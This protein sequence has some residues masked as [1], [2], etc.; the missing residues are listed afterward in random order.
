[1]DRKHAEFDF[2]LRLQCSIIELD[3][4]SDPDQVRNMIRFSVRS[5]KSPDYTN[6]QL[7]A[8]SNKP[9]P[10]LGM[11]PDE[12]C[13]STK[14]SCDHPCA[15]F[16]WCMT[17]CIRKVH[18]TVTFLKVCRFFTKTSKTVS[19]TLWPLGWWSWSEL[20]RVV[21][22]KKQ[23]QNEIL[24]KQTVSPDQSGYWQLYACMN[25]RHHLPSHR[26]DSSQ[27]QLSGAD[28][29]LGFGQLVRG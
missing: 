24:M 28:V 25:C 19:Q 4:K 3:K 26:V 14:S 6:L 22:I 10:H 21:N 29:D 9:Q 17:K 2:P 23:M 12:L 16:C 13:E 5:L 27:Q 20:W 15:C 1:M 8:K 7:A 11:Q 18:A